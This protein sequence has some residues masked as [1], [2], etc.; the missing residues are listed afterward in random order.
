M[1]HA[2]GAK[3]PTHTENW[4]TLPWKQFQRN[5]FHL[6]QRIYRASRR[7]DW[8]YCHDQIHSKGYQ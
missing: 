7:G 5:V 1:A 2:A 3:E 8:Q 4:Q 6:E